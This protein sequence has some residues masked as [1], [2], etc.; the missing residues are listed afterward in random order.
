ML[1]YLTIFEYLNNNF[2]GLGCEAN[3]IPVGK[4]D[5]DGY[6]IKTNTE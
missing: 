4:G 6:R 5:F 1:S 2:N 3:K